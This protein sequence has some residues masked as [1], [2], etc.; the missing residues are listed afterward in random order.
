[1]RAEMEKNGSPWKPIRIFN[2]LFIAFYAK[3]ISQTNNNNNKRKGE[4][5]WLRGYGKTCFSFSCFHLGIVFSFDTRNL[6]LIPF[7]CC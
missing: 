4:G 3:Q 6:G 2:L 7:D 5:I 1:M